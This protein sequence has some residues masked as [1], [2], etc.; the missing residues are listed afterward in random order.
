VQEGRLTLNPHYCWVDVWAFEHILNEVD[1]LPKEDQVARGQL[2]EK[3]LSLYKGQFL[4]EVM[5]SVWIISM[6]EKLRSKFIRY[7]EEYGL[8]LEKTER[9][10]DAIEWYQKG[11]EID[12]LAEQFYQRLMYCFEQLDRRSDAVETYR[13]CYRILTN[14]LDVEPSRKTKEIYARIRA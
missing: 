10:S 5:D 13:Q 3:A 8:I 14:S 2:I 9:W 11:L 7:L 4:Q 6:R 12:L 1:K